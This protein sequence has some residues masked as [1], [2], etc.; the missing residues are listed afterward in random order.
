MEPSWCWCWSRKSKLIKHT[1]QG[2]GLLVTWV[3]DRVCDDLCLM[4]GMNGTD[5]G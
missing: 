2:E 1:R 5:E 4:L 3:M